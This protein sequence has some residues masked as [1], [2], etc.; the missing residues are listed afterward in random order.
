MG[1]NTSVKVE[2]GSDLAGKVVVSEV[3][4]IINPASG[5]VAGDAYEFILT[6]DGFQYGG[7]ILVTL[8]YVGESGKKAV[9]YYWNGT[10]AEKMNVVEYTENSVTFETSHNSIY[11]I[12]T[13]DKAEN[14]NGLLIIVAVAVVLAIIV[15]GSA[16]YFEVVRNRKA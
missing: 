10:E 13:E 15:S 2:S 1:S 5:I 8:P 9:V 3:K 14:M 12:A 11:I 6:A 7:K 16:Y 4:S